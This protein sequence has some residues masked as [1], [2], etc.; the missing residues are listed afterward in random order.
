MPRRRADKSLAPQR[1]FMSSLLSG[2]PR[3]QLQAPTHSDRA[4]MPPQRLT[5]GK[6]RV[7]ERDT[8]RYQ[9]DPSLHYHLLLWR[10]Y[11]EAR[12]KG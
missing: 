1:R 10:R 4:S 6:R 3:K 8:H 7:L 2:L 5:D 9:K 12:E 11:G